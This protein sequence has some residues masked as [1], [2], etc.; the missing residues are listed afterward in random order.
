V[1]RLVA[2][3]ARLRRPLL[4]AANLLSPDSPSDKGTRELYDAIKDE[5]KR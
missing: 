5:A 3:N 1:R 4:E 2:N